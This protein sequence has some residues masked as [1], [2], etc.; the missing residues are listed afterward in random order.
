M[1]SIAMI[2]LLYMTLLPVAGYAGSDD[3]WLKRDSVTGSWGGL[4][5]ALK[6][7]GV[8]IELMYTGEMV[9]NFSGGVFN[10]PGSLYHD[11]LDLKLTAESDKLGLWHGGR[12]LVYGLRNHGAQPSVSLI[13]DLH[14][15]SNIEA[16]DQFIV[17]EAW[18]EQQ[19]LDGRLSLLAGLH[20]LNSE[21][22]I[23]EYGSLFL[24]S[25]FG[26]GPDISGNVTASIFPRPGLGLR[27]RARP[28]EQVYIQAAV[29]DGDPATRAIKRMEG[30]MMIAEAGYVIT[31][32]AGYKLGCWR[33]TADRIYAGR[34]FSGDY[35]V[36]GTID[37]PL[38]EFDGG[39]KAGLFLQYGWVPADRN[40]NIRYIGGGVHLQGLIRGRSLDEA[41]VA[42]ARADTHLDAE[43]TLELTYR[44]VLY[45]WLAIQPSFQWIDNP[46]GDAKVHAAKVGLLRFSIAL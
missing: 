31:G 22:Y 5:D 13:G 19:W 12:W 44:L 2:L 21:F 7:Q 23:T 41:G 37:Q 46:G 30:R 1:R 43:T 16:P 17:Y 29:Y 18:Y 40:R 33:H 35:G 14:T 24:N 27:L 10:R 9:R 36:Y 6:D 39:G 42:I 32:G 4:R 8:D 15:V 20:D 28:S 26:I 38:F 11:N 3:H 25:S 45:P 34:S